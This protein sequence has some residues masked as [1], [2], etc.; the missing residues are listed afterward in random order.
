MKVFLSKR[1]RRHLCW[2]KPASLQQVNPIQ[3]EGAAV[4]SGKEIVTSAVN[5]VEEMRQLV[6]ACDDAFR[7]IDGNAANCLAFARGYNGKAQRG[8]DARIA[9]NFRKAAP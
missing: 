4:L 2:I 7:A 3:H 5:Y 1:H 9:E 8:Y 6:T